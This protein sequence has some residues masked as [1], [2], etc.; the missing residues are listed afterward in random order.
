MNRSACFIQNESKRGLPSPSVLIGVPDPEGSAS[1]SSWVTDCDTTTISAVVNW[2]KRN[3]GLKPMNQLTIFH[4]HFL[5][6]FLYFYILAGV[7]HHVRTLPQ[8]LIRS[9]QSFTSSSSSN[10]SAKRALRDEFKIAVSTYN[11]ANISSILQGGLL[12]RRRNYKYK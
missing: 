11:Y 1:E 8:M 4:F 6:F 3:L 7:S 9:S 2:A 5:I 12:L 10:S